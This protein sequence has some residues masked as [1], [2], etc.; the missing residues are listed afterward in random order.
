M[1]K[2]LLFL[3]ICFSWNT[4]IN[5]DIYEIY[6]TKQATTDL[7]WTK[8][9]TK[10]DGWEEVSS[11]YGH[12]TVRSYQ[13]CPEED[14]IYPKDNWIRSP[15]ISAKEGERIYI[16]LE[17]SIDQCSSDKKDAKCKETFNLFYYQAKADV[18]SSTFPPWRENPYKKID[19]VA[20]N[21]GSQE[22]NRKTFSV[23][24]LKRKGLYI[25][26]QDQGAC[27]SILSVRLYYYYCN[28][29]YK[30]LAV[31]P[32]TVSGDG[33]ASLVTAPGTCVANAIYQGDKPLYRCSSNGNWKIPTG[34]CSCGE[35]YEESDDLTECI[36]CSAGTYKLGAGK[37]KCTQ[38]PANSGLPALNLP[39]LSAQEVE[40]RTIKHND[41]PC[42]SG[43][44][45][46]EHEPISMACTR[47]PTAPLT[48]GASSH[49]STSVRLTWEEPQDN[50]SRDDLYYSVECEQSDVDVKK[51]QPCSSSVVVVAPKRNGKLYTERAI[52]VGLTPH[53]KYQ[54]TVVS[55]NGASDALQ[56]PAN[57]RESK[58]EVNTSEEA[59]S[60]VPNIQMTA[61]DETS[62]TISWPK[63]TRP[64][65]LILAY[66]VVSQRKQILNVHA[67]KQPD[68][69]FVQ[70]TTENKLT[71]TLKS[72]V[73]YNVRVRAKTSAGYGPYSPWTTVHT[74]S[75][76]NTPSEPVTGSS[77]NMVI[78]IAAVC[79]ILF[80][81][82]VAF[83]VIRYRSTG[84]L[85]CLNTSR[86]PKK[87]QDKNALKKLGNDM[88]PREPL[89]V[90]LPPPGQRLYVEYP[91]PQKAIS[92]I[93][94]EFNIRDIVTDDVI[95]VG[96]FA[97]VLRGSLRGNRCPQG[98]VV[99]VKRLKPG[100][101]KRDQSNFLREASTMAQ[102]KDPNIVQLLGVVTKAPPIM[103]ITEYME[104][105]SLD[106]YLEDNKGQLSIIQL[107]TMLRGIASGMRYLSSIKYVHRDLAARNILVNSDL[108]CKVS[109]FGLSRTLENDPH[110]TY[111]TQG[112]KI[113]I[114]WTAPECIHYREF[115]SATDVWS[116]G[117]V[118]WEVM[119]YA[120]KPY[121]D[122]SNQQV[123]ENINKGMRLPAP[124]GCP[125]ILHDLMLECWSAEAAKRPPF[126]DLVRNLDYLLEHPEELSDVPAGTSQRP[127]YS[128]IRATPNLGRAM[129]RGQVNTVE[130]WLDFQRLSGYSDQFRE[131][132]IDSLEK[133]SNL[134]I[135]DLKSLG[136][137]VTI[138]VDRLEDGIRT[139]KRH[140]STCEST[141]CNS[142]RTSNVSDAIAE[143]TD[144]LRMESAAV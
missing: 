53:K 126:A 79:A 96:E 85:L 97:E 3:I 6:N 139:L 64:N 9:A 86:V 35:G 54:F 66:E 80:I 113:A 119:S 13:A 89:I 107:L 100:H 52:M 21:A 7:D 5:A 83:I 108:V 72:N 24:S 133:V 129:D 77:N 65:G 46:A 26:I 98:Q 123:L 22:I 32:R 124:T 118:M 55:H 91:D 50:G 62:V 84:K 102:F 142:A 135:N 130:Q 14:D 95:G 132:G 109:D 76:T 27:M 131:R 136:I 82:L 23:G 104:N 116:F 69:P 19:T 87:Q 43:Y 112:G 115:T 51:F 36:E 143:E 105:K 15:Y 12:G 38:C 74:A 68:A 101:T 94:K 122:M 134:T 1:I 42:W 70:T 67:L 47:P 37:H 17:Y 90:D 11:L 99:A 44:A 20:A 92:E 111:T 33:P 63:P 138:H 81:V 121:W 18:A 110:A 59:P 30:N 45:R 48:L 141:P 49:N 93:A 73:D 25:A 127:D 16:D 137:N 60:Q 114:R 28:M 40:K 2:Q 125:K 103:I 34:E 75:S 78:I 106:K 71:L 39:R 88:L 29:V 140:M 4:Q 31:F 61:R 56:G 117:I 120:E 57:L 41:C 128:R 10:G 144:P 58:V 8:H